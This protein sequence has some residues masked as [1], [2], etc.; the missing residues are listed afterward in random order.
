M[1]ATS[2]GAYNPPI[3]AFHSAQQRLGRLQRQLSRKVKFSNNWSKL[4]KKIP[5]LHWHTAN[6]REDYLQKSSCPLSKNYAIVCIEDLS[7]SNMSRLAK[8]TIENPRRNIK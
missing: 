4:V 6:I 2:D 7:V 3:N 1:I 8:G 5:K